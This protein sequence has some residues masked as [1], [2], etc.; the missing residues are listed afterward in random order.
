[1]IISKRIKPTA[2]KTVNKR[3]NL[4]ENMA[5]RIFVFVSIGSV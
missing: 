4:A 5:F 1:M 3:K 2:D